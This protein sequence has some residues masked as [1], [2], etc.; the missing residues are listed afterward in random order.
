[1]YFNFRRI[2]SAGGLWLLLS[3]TAV[4]SA[5]PLQPGDKFPALGDFSL[6][7]PRPDLSAAKVTIVDFWASWCAPCKASFP[8]FD[9][10]H[11][12]FAPEGL[13]IVA[14]S[15]DEK[16]RAMRTFLAR[17]DPPF[18]VLR[19]A[20]QKL[21]AQAQIPSMPTAFVLDAQGVV[22]F[23]HVGF[24]GE[25]SVQQYRQ[26]IRSLLAESS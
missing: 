13:L 16:E 22:R 4:L 23:V 7:G 3:S 10:L 5:A 20:E 14:V 1:M 9:A 6:A 18:I 15:V 17:F 25:S 2:V 8:A 11:R 12:E 24:H 21:V 19:D 26:E